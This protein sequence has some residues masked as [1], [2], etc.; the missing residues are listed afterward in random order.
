MRRFVCVRAVC[1]NETM[2][3]PVFEISLMTLDEKS[4]KA[5]AVFDTGSFY[6]ILREDK[7]PSGAVVIRRATPLE[8]RGA[9]KGSKLTVTGAIEVVMTIG[10][11]M[12]EDSTLVSPDLAQEM[13]VGAKTMQ[14]WDISVINQNGSTS[15]VVGRDMRDPHITEVD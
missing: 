1:Y 11:K 6:T 7:V 3:K 9:S 5:E 12:I 4:G 15:V 10:E 8:F 14:A 13:L 2:S